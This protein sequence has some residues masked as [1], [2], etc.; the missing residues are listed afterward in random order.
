[1]LKKQERWELHQSEWTCQPGY[2]SRVWERPSV[3]GVNT[4]IAGSCKDPVSLGEVRDEER[5]LE[6]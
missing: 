4:L 1:M 3:P 6:E 5:V 2:Q